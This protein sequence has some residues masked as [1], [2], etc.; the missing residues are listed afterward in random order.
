MRPQYQNDFN[1]WYIE[2]G[3]I[4][5]FDGEYNVG[6]YNHQQQTQTWFDL[7]GE[8]NMQIYQGQFDGKSFITNKYMS[9]GFDD[10]IVNVKTFEIVCKSNKTSYASLVFHYN[11][12]EYKYDRD[13]QFVG[14]SFR[15][16]NTV[17]FR[18]YGDCFSV[19]PLNIA[20]YTNVNDLQL[21]HNGIQQTS[22]GS[23]ASFYV[24]DALSQPNK[25]YVSG[26]G[27]PLNKNQYVFDGHIYNIR[28]YNR[29]LSQDEIIH[30]HLVDK[31]RFN[32]I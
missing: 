18:G 27:Y 16:N 7:Y 4:S 31:E 19:N 17:N 6:F 26:Y 14:F 15:G 9:A 13:Y 20:T 24:K 22:I 10:F 21:Y 29:Q 12:Y 1:N 25:S 28:L 30:N 23:G 32:I 8:E 11:C 3:I 2:D 5:M